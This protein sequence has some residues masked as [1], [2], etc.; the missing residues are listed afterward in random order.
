MQRLLLPT[1]IQKQPALARRIAPDTFSFP[2][3]I[4]ASM[5]SLSQRP[6]SLSP[7]LNPP[8]VGVGRTVALN[9]SLR[10][11]TNSQTV[12]VTAQQGLLS[13]DNPNTTT[14]I[15][16]KTD[17]EP[18]QPRPGPDLSCPVRTGRA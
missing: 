17:Q 6:V 18:P 2:R 8:S 13:L 9:F 14:T 16:A 11:Q 1:S 7:G 4:P 3:S 10:V 12:E 15:E 5:W